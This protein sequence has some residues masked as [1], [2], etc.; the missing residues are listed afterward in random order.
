MTA[1]AAAH[2][3]GA[4]PLTWLDGVADDEPISIAAETKGGGDDLRLV[5]KDGSI[6]EIQIKKGLSQGASL[7]DAMEGLGAAIHAGTATYGVLVVSP[8]STKPVK[9]DLAGGVIQIAEGKSPKSGSPA[10]TLQKRFTARG[11]NARAVCARIRV[12]TVAATEADAADVRAAIAQM[13]SLLRK[14]EQARAAWDRLYRD[15]HA[16]QQGRGVRSRA[17]IAQVL[18][19]AGHSLKDDPTAPSGMIE[20]LRRWTLEINADFTI[21]GAPKP[22]SLEKGFI[23]L[24]PYVRQGDEVDAS[25]KM[26]LATAI[27]RYQDWDGRLPDRDAVTSAPVAL[28]RYYTRVVLVAGPGAGKSTLLSRVATAYAADGFP[29]LKASAKSVARRMENGEGFEAALLHHALGGSSITPMHALASGV[30]D[31][32]VLLDGLDEIGPMQ[33]TVIE[34]LKAFTAGHPLARVIVTTRPVGYHGAQLAGWRQYEVPGVGE[35]EVAGNLA[36]LI[37]EMLDPEDPRQPH[38]DTLV[39]QALDA[40]PSARTALRTPLMLGL[41]AA[42]LT[43]GRSLGQSRTAFYREVLDLLEQASSSRLT[44][45]PPT[46]QR[47]RLFLDLLGWTLTTDPKASRDKALKAISSGMATTFGLLPLP[48]EEQAEACLAYWE[49]LGVVET[50]QHGGDRAL[51]FVHKTF[52]EFTAG[53]YLAAAAPELQER[54]LTASVSDPGLREAVAFAAAEGLAPFALDRFRTLGFEYDAGEA[55]LLQALDLLVDSRPAVAGTIAEPILQ[56]ALAAIADDRNQ[57]VGEVGLRLRSLVAAYPD[58]LAGAA[59]RLI[60][61]HQPWT[62]IVGLAIGYATRPDNRP[63]SDWIDDLAHHSEAKALPSARRRLHASSDSMVNVLQ[64]FAEDLAKTIVVEL[65]PASATDVFQRAFTGPDLQR[66]GFIL[67]MQKLIDGSGIEPWWRGLGGQGSIRLPG[68]AA[69]LVKTSDRAFVALGRSL[70]F[71]AP[72]PASPA[73]DNRPL[74]ALSAFMS[75]VNFGGTALSEVWPLAQFGEDDDVRWLWRSLARL[76][77]ISVEGLSHDAAVFTTYLETFDGEGLTALF[78]RTFEVDLPIAW[79]RA[80]DLPVDVALLESALRRPSELVMHPARQIAAQCDQETIRGF[81]TRLL[82]DGGDHALRA[83]AKLAKHLPA[84]DACDLLFAHA[85]TSMR[86]G[87]QYVLA[88]LRDLEA[89]SDPRAPDAIRNAI[90]SGDVDTAMYGAAWAVERNDPELL[91]TLKDTYRL[92]DESIWSSW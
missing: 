65:D 58:W 77:G 75:A 41:A 69:K 4:A 81:V 38:L 18:R 49:A 46:A 29:V 60:D 82:A 9:D 71:E 83:A 74:P 68:S 21:I 8:S 42:L 6:V 36:A 52:G 54:T 11:W 3:V 62:R 61:H 64:I 10:E 85:L 7:W 50:L 56:A 34:G 76:A 53:R 31:W 90:G 37:S 51:V 55:R 14:P 73:D 17:A 16:M 92:W 5:L 80:P 22:I 27:S 87:S 78:K 44:V 59:E 40:S 88:A 28:G 84:A 20:R 63:L 70:Q 35:D 30:Q 39:A 86:S 45:Q 23:E 79:E 91:P 26:D 1:I 47:R 72:L 89:D 12:I 2:S 25:R 66:A 15:A 33:A 48:A 24:A 57:Y 32:V 43:A 19:S 67:G 13:T